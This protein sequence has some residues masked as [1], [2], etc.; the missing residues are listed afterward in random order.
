V[1]SAKVSPTRA[2]RANGGD[3]TFSGSNSFA[4][5]NFGER[6]NDDTSSRYLS[7]PT[8]VQIFA[9]QGNEWI[10]SSKCR[11][12]VGAN[13]SDP[14]RS[15]E[16]VTFEVLLTMIDFSEFNSVSHDPKAVTRLTGMQKNERVF[17]G[18]KLRRNNAGIRSIGR[19]HH[20][21]DGIRLKL[22]V[23]VA[24]EKECGTLNHENGFITGSPEA[25]ILFKDSDEGVG[26]DSRQSFGDVLSIP[27]RHDE[28][29]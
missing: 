1:S 3:E 8:Q 2:L 12:E 24:E 10:K 15:D 18:H 9:Q 4:M 22:H 6:R 7:S 29:A 20:E 26:S 23:I 5:S 27:V 16:D 13:K 28:Q 17:V 25:S 19:F 21:L 14:A 11:E